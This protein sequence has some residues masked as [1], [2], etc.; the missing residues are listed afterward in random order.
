MNWKFFADTG[1]KSLADALFKAVF[2]TV[3]AAYVTF[4]GFDRWHIL[5]LKA[6]LLGPVLML[7]LWLL[8]ALCW[9]DVQFYRRR[10]KHQD[11]IA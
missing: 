3:T 9:R 8:A 10:K 7:V 1:S 5:S 11:D 6:K 2:T 4:S